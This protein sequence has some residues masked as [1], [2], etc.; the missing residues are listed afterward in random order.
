MRF[1]IVF[2]IILH[3]NSRHFSVW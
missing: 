2:C 1:D 3:H